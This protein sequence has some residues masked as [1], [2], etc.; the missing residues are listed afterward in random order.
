MARRDLA[1][2]H[3][4]PTPRPRARY[5]APRRLTRVL[6]T[7]VRA[8]ALGRGA[9]SARPPAR[10]A[11]WCKDT[12]NP[13]TRR[14]SRGGETAGLPGV[15]GALVCA[16]AS[17]AVWPSGDPPSP[18]FPSTPSPS[19]RV[20]PARPSRCHAPLGGTHPLAQWHHAPGYPIAP[21]SASADDSRRQW[22]THPPFPCARS[23]A[24]TRR[25]LRRR[26]TLRWTAPPAP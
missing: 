16:R 4:T 21:V 10:A 18:S 6:A 19:C 23:P 24:P 12:C 13:L 26:T 5:A 9:S 25:L 20:R 22:L 8:Q 17:A 11:R 3:S 7:R 2:L 1:N 14:A 15:S